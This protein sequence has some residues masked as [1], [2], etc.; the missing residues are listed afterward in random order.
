MF[1][2]PTEKKTNI[3]SNVGGNKNFLKKI[4]LAVFVVGIILTGFI[5]GWGKTEITTQKTIIDGWEFPREEGKHSNFKFEGWYFA[6]H[7]E[8]EGNP[9]NKFGVTLA[10]D[11]DQL[12]NQLIRV[13]LVDGVQKKNFSSKIEIDQYDLLSEKK[14]AIKKDENYWLEEELF[15]YKIHFQFDNNEIDLSLDSLKP[16]LLR[17]NITDA[18]Y[19]QQTR[20]KTVGKLSFSGKE[21]KV[22]GWGWIDHLGLNQVTF[23]FLPAGWR[24]YAIQLDNNTEIVST[25]FDPRLGMRILK[26]PALFLYNKDAQLE[27]IEGNRYSIDDIDYWV[28][29]ETN[30]EYPVRSR[31]EIPDKN[32]NLEITAITKNQVIREIQKTFLYEGSCLVTGL[33]DG[34]NITGRA[35]LEVIHP[36]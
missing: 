2:K 24:W 6:G 33:F 19:Y 34:Q 32:I 4:I 21:Y 13:N 15:K 30:H 23:T 11:K 3:F 9:E 10:F 29:P 14:L 8:E 1:D 35:Q 5:F 28:D 7:L 36:R 12:T 22:K 25:H 27:I 17:Y 20:V 31:L 26:K 18:F 16:P